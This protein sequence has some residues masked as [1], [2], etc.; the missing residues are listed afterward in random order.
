MIYADLDLESVQKT[1]Q[2]LI[3]NM[4]IK[5]IVAGLS[6]HI[7]NNRNVYVMNDGRISI[8]LEWN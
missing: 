1:L 4:K 3:S 8:P 7:S 6:I 5:N 2:R